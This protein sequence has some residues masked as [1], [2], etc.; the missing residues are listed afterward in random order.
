MFTKFQKIN[1]TI[2]SIICLIFIA[3]MIIKNIDFSINCKQYLKRAADANSVELALVNLNIAI[4]YLEDNNLT[5]GVVSIFLRQPKN[6]IGFWYNNLVSCRNE[7]D[8][9]N[10]ETTALE[11]T[12]ILMKLRET[13]LDV[14]ETGSYVTHPGDI[15]V[16]PH[17]K[18]FFWVIFICIINIVWCGL[19]P[20]VIMV[21]KY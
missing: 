6:D 18:L 7:L 3:M 16:Y 10:L 9:V 4:K 20:L 13:L 19:L 12:N 1:L 15:A 5:N 2:W 21:F 14:K 17:N 8:K 11:K